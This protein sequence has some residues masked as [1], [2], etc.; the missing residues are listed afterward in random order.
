MQH[1]GTSESITCVIVTY[2]RAEQLRTCLLRTLRQAV[3]R[4]VVIDNGST[5]GTEALLNEFSQRDGRLVV[6]RQ[7]RA[8]GGSWGFARGVRLADRLQGKQGWLLLFDD[9][10]WPEQDCIAR[11]R[12]R[13]S[14]YACRKVAAVGAAVFDGQGRA[15]ES[16]RPV[17]NLFQRPRA[18]IALTARNSS[19]MRDL[20]HVPHRLLQQGGRQLEVDAI[21]FVGLFL[22]LERLPEGK[23]RYPR[24]GLFLYSDDTTYTLE[25]VRSGRLLLLDTDLRFRH[26]SQGGGAAIR[27]LTPI[28]KHYYVVRNSFLMNRSLSQFWYVP[29]CVATVITHGSRALKD[30]WRTRDDTHLRL[31]TLGCWDGIRNSYNRRHSRLE[32]MVTKCGKHSSGK[33]Q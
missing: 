20:Y 5:D 22:N 11:F 28:W 19:C 3:D 8:K 9:D 15:V 18:V 27:R 7:R 32:G 2:N 12:A 31:I 10:A 33:M 30:Y 14:G 16:N 13:M 17:L 1:S 23:G 29:L 24:G 21:S 25:L 6:E 4:V 26:E